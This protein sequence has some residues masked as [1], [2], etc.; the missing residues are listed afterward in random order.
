MGNT[1]LILEKEYSIGFM[2]G[3]KGSKKRYT[4]PNSWGDGVVVIHC[5]LR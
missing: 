4:K 5:G 3:K 2:N 1:F